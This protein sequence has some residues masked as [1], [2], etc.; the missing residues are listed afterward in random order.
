MCVNLV[1][2]HAA[3]PT[4][5]VVVV[6]VGVDVVCAGVVVAVPVD[7]PVEFVLFGAAVAACMTTFQRANTRQQSP[8]REGRE[9]QCQCTRR[10]DRAQVGTCKNTRAVPAA[11]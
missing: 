6:L 3:A 7:C 5:L 8:R 4:L 10:S 9:A 2:P 11:A 1:T